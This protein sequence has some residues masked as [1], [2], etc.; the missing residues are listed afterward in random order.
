MDRTCLWLGFA[1]ALLLNTTSWAARVPD[2]KGHML[3]TRMAPVLL[4]KAVPPFK[5]VHVYQPEKSRP[6]NRK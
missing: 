3:H 6:S 5:G 2:G 4:H 1:M